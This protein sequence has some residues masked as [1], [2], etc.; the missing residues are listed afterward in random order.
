MLIEFER[1]RTPPKFSPEVGIAPDRRRRI[2]SN[3]R[4]GQ[5]EVDVV[6]PVRR[7][8]FDAKLVDRSGLRA[9]LRLDNVGARADRHDLRR[10]YRKRERKLTLFPGGQDYLL[11]DERV[12]ARSRR[13]DGIGAR[14]QQQQTVVSLPVAGRRAR[15]TLR[16]VRDGHG[17]V[18]NDGSGLVVNRTVEL[19]GRDVLGP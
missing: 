9:A 11:T 13:L 14:R 19:R 17:G 6:A 18:R 8:I 16:L 5:R 3:L 1:A 2:A 4:V 15:E 7:Q 12:E 10:P